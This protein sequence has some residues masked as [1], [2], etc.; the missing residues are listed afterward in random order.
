MIVLLSPIDEG[1]VT[2]YHARLVRHDGG[3]L[4][5]DCVDAVDIDGRLVSEGFEIMAVQAKWFCVRKLE[6]EE[7]VETYV[8][9]QER[10]ERFLSLNEVKLLEVESLEW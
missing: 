6:P 9:S 1:G 8:L 2:R 7:F 4:Y 5:E 10:R 3:V